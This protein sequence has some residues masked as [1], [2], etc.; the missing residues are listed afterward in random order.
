MCKMRKVYD[1]YHDMPEEI[2]TI[3]R[4]KYEVGCNGCYFEHEVLGKTYLDE[5]D[6]GTGVITENEE[7]SELDAWFC[8]NG[9]FVGEHVII[10]YWW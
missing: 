9:A 5:M 8:E 10:L 2:R 1:I 7:Y 6:D 3:V 4:E